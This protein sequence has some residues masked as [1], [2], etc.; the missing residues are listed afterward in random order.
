MTDPKQ[1]VERFLRSPEAAR[2]AGGGV[3]WT[4]A[5]ANREQIDEAIRYFAHCRE[6]GRTTVPWRTFAEHVIV[7]G[8]FDYPFKHR[9]VIKHAEDCLGIQT[10]QG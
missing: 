3:C 7:R 8:D 6:Q 2:H 1:N 4:C 10:K 5:L 9:A